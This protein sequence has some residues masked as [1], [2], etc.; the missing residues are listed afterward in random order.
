MYLPSYTGSQNLGWTGR[1]GRQTWRQEG[2]NRNYDS[3][4]VY[5]TV[6]FLLFRL[7]TRYW[8]R[9]STWSSLRAVLTSK[10]CG[11]FERSLFSTSVRQ[12]RINY[13]GCLRESMHLQSYYTLH[14]N[15]NVPNCVLGTVDDAT[16]IH[17]AHLYIYVH[18]YTYVYA[19]VC[20]VRS[21]HWNCGS[22]KG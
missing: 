1:A 18:V 16:F 12:M 3:R 9:R 7:C 13:E 8:Q 5:S 10:L 6:G 17:C 2:I 4:L 20:T 19:Y 22:C 21:Y 14:S 11:V 15:E